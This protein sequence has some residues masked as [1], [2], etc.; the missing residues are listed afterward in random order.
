MGHQD[1]GHFLEVA[2]LTI[3][4]NDNIFVRPKK[5]IFFLS[6]PDF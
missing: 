5:E 6:F 3:T 4:E 1:L 2:I